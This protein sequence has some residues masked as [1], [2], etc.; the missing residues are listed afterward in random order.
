M[1][2]SDEA[3]GSTSDEHNTADGEIKNFCVVCMEHFEHE[4]K[5]KVLP[6]FHKV[7]P[8][9]ENIVPLRLC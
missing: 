6:C 2:L 4:N 7:T 3:G 9:S 8:A 1:N 5:I